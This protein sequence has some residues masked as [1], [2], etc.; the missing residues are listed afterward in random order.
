MA[1]ALAAL[2]LASNIVQFI[3]FGLKTTSEIK[4][5]YSSASGLTSEI[6][7]LND[8]ATEHRKTVA[9]LQKSTDD[10]GPRLSQEDIELKT[11][12][13]KTVITA[14]KLE[15]IIDPLRTHNAKPRVRD[16]VTKGWKS[17]RSKDKL[18]TVTKE[19]QSYKSVLDTRLLINVRFTEIA[20]TLQLP[21]SNENMHEP[22]WDTNAVRNVLRWLKEAPLGRW[23][24]IVDSIDDPEWGV[25]NLIPVSTKGTV[26]ITSQLQ[27]ANTLFPKGS[28][29]LEVYTMN[30]AEAKTLLLRDIETPTLADEERQ[31]SQEIVE[32]LGNLPLAVDLARAVITNSRHRE[33]AVRGYLNDLQY[34]KDIVL[35]KTGLKGLTQYQKTLSNVWDIS[36][37]AVQTHSFSAANLLKF[38]SFLDPYAVQDEMWRLASQGLQELR[39]DGLVDNNNFPKWLEALLRHNGSWCDSL[40]EDDLRWL[41]TYSLVRP[42]TGEW[43]GVSMHRLVQW[44]SQDEILRDEYK[45]WTMWTILFQAAVSI[46][47]LEEA[48]EFRRHMIVHLNC[49]QQLPLTS[50]IDEYNWIFGRLYA[51]EGWWDEAEKLQVDVMEKRTAKL[52]P[53][54][55]NTLR[56]MANLAST[57]WKQGR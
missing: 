40:Y 27:N 17:W 49:L 35:K 9:S 41:Q 28:E 37:K 56:S 14:R 29:I 32:L 24:V 31:A 39:E 30:D 6:T 55:P 53:D 15:D 4:E 44:R 48:F 50:T 7:T 10:N 13:T 33:R 21:R 16:A 38:L 26:I 45:S 12:A 34:R 22:V 47:L 20:D 51:D 3:D 25:R 19:L 23:L 54:H 43:S 57:Y 52:G 42:L 18:E 5:I 8:I 2:G 1:E 11:L 46:R 36:I